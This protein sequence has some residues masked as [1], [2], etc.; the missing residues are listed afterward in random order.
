M[1]ARG[2]DDTAVDHPCGVLDVLEGDSHVWF[3]NPVEIND[4]GIE[5][6]AAI[7]LSMHPPSQDLSADLSAEASAKAEAT[8]VKPWRNARRVP[9]DLS[10]D[11]SAVALAKVEALMGPT[12]VKPWGSTLRD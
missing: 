2:P 4:E 1:R 6:D 7:P 12:A 9:S 5:R 10:A 8:A 3:S 11:L